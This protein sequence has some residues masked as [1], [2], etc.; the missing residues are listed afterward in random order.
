MD[1]ANQYMMVDYN[2][3]PNPY[4]HNLFQPQQYNGYYMQN[5][6]PYNYSEPAYPNYL[7]HQY[8]SPYDSQHPDTST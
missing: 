4:S 7:P 1:K 5:Y 2:A 8:L 3:N 6:L